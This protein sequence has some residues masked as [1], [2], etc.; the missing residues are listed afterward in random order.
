MRSCGRGP[1]PSLWLSG[2]SR[3]RGRR[4]RNLGCRVVSSGP[5]PGAGWWGRKGLPGSER[6]RGRGCVAHGELLAQGLA[7][8]GGWFLPS[9]QGPKMSVHQRHRKQK[10]TWHPPPSRLSFPLRHRDLGEGPAAVPC[11]P[12]C[13]PAPWLPLLPPGCTCGSAL[14]SGLS[15]PSAGGRAG[16]QT[17]YLQPK[18]CNL[19]DLG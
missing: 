19:V 18:H 16:V 14:P 5:G 10:H 17:P 13:L 6:A 11:T 3:L 7:G 15:S 8:P 2:C 1:E 4:L 12:A 9:Q